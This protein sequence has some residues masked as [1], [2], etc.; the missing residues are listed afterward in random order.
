MAFDH[1]PS[2]RA[3]SGDVPEPPVQI[4]TQLRPSSE[5]QRVAP[6][7]LTTS[8]HTISANPLS[9]SDCGDEGDAEAGSDGDPDASMY[10]GW[11]PDMSV[12]LLR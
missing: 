12:P 7:P 9:V 5:Q 3:V 10:T 11:L 8:V 1:V 4:D 2:A 6:R